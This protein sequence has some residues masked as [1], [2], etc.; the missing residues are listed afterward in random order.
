M[1]TSKNSFSSRAILSPCIVFA[2][3]LIV[4]RVYKEILLYPNALLFGGGKSLE[5][6]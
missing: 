3:V 5:I 4:V 6:E 1:T 2:D